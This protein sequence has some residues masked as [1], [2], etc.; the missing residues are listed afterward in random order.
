MIMARGF[1]IAMQTIESVKLQNKQLSMQNE[2]QKQQILNDAPLVE[3]A[4]DCYNSTG[5]YT[6]SILSARLGFK[7]ANALNT[8]LKNK[9]YNIR[10]K[11]MIAGN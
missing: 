1:Q 6:A 5:S 9:V 4:K 3:L 11:V 8:E 2:I 7:S 10:L